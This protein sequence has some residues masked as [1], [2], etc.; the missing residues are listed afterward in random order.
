M[1]TKVRSPEFPGRARMVG[2]E[3]KGSG[4]VMPA[5]SG[6]VNVPVVTKV[7]I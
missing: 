1:Q 5:V 2:N 4:L 3:R 6:R 7:S